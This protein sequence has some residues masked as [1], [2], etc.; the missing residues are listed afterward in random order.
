M[1]HGAHLCVDM[2]TMFA[3][4]TEWAAP[5]MSRVLPAIAALSEKYAGST[6]FTRFVPALRPEA[7]AG[8]WQRYYQRWPNMTRERLHPDLIE[9]VPDLRRH[10]PPA[11]QFDKHT[12]SP[13]H[14]GRLHRL[15]QARGARTL[16][17]SGGETDIC[18]LATMLGAIDRGYRV[19]L[20]EDALFGSADQTHDAILTVYRNRFGQQLTMCRTEDVLHHWEDLA[21]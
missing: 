11:V 8:G 17:I 3:A 7:A 19:V 16:L 13:W 6:I 9:I 2:Q 4:D 1:K 14:G 12:Y 5:W 21:A 18:V 10:I 20:A 15:L